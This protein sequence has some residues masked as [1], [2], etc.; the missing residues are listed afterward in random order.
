MPHVLPVAQA[1][2][3]VRRRS[4]HL[5]QTAKDTAIRTP[6]ISAGTALPL[7]DDDHEASSVQTSNADVASQ[8]KIAPETVTTTRAGHGDGVVGEALMA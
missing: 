2:G 7:R 4:C 1:Q 3:F 5:G 8:K 6:Q